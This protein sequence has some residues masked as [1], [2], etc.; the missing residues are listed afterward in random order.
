MRIHAV[1]PVCEPLD[2]RVLFAI[3]AIFVLAGHELRI[4]GD[5]QDNVIV[6]SRDAA[7]TIFV[8]GGSVPILNGPAT[9]QTTANFH[10]IGGAGADQISLDE[11]N[12]LLPLAGIFGGDGNDTLTGGS[13][14][15]FIDGGTG[16]DDVFLGGGD[17]AFQWNPGDGS[18]RIEAG[19]G[20][21]MLV[22]NGSDLAETF[23][24]S[25]EAGH[26][27]LTRDV[28]N[29]SMDLHGLEQLE[30]NVFGGADMVNFNDLS[31]TGLLEVDLD[32]SAATLAAD[33]LADFVVIN[34]SDRPE[35]IPVVGTAAGVL[36][37][38]GFLTRPGLPYFVAI[39]EVDP[40]D[41]LR[42]NGNGG[43][44]TLSAS[45]DTPVVLEFDGG[46]QHDTLDVID[47]APTG[48]VRVLPSGGDDAVY[49]NL[50][51]VGVAN[52]LFDVTQ[53][54]GQL[55][56]NSGGLVTLASGG[57]KVLTVT[58]L[59]TAGTGRLDVGDNTLI[60]DYDGVSELGAV[61]S[62][63]ISGRNGGTWNGRGIMTR[64]GNATTSA[65][66]YAEASDVAPGGTF[67]GQPVDATAVVVRFTLYGDADLD[68]RVGPS[69]FNR[70][71]TH[72]GQPGAF[73][74]AGDFNFDRAVDGGDFNLLATNFGKAR[75]PQ[76]RMGLRASRL[77]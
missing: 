61:Q 76:L 23:T 45:L 14:E 50:D 31:T 18:D 63:L 41:I 47:T 57:D 8:N 1:P 74:A 15:D 48:V 67:A 3:T 72:F 10:I 69:D 4:V 77:R 7:G 58:G 12:G 68:G 2:A 59:V 64:F 35:E 16:N 36:V 49:V 26:I 21:D 39:R 65:L 54:I 19:T 9:T 66:G 38:G 27:H 6:V 28:G 25:A 62:V 46:A 11:T 52:V 71:A 24:A 17:D 20:H 53:R 43:A 37:N 13:G 60:D 5:D 30:L 34:G 33:G 40:I 56:L 75:A 70:L 44:D 55:D 42:I 29:V 73:W 51:G 22:F 32:L